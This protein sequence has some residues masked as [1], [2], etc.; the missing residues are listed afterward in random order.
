MVTNDTKHVLAVIISFGGE[1]G[2]DRWTQR[3]SELF[4]QFASANGCEIRKV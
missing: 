4:T 3:T 2:L 1:A